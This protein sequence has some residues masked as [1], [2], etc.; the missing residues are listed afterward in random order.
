MS[1]L[2]MSATHRLGFGH[3]SRSSPASIARA[4]TF[5]VLDA[6][7]GKRA[8]VGVV[9]EAGKAPYLRTHADGYYNDNLLALD[10]CP[11]R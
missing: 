2:P 11:L 7:T 9:R 6:R 4:N 3:A 5:F 10:Q 1:T 8:D